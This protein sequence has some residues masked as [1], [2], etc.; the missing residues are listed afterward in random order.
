MKGQVDIL[1]VIQRYE[2]YKY[3]GLT[4]DFLFVI[5]VI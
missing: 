5:T 1:N 2:P 4:L 3:L